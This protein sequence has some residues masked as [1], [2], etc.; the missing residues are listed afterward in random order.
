MGEDV[1]GFIIYR[2]FYMGISLLSSE[3]KGK[4][5]EALFADMGEGE[6]PSLDPVTHAIFNMMLPS[7]HDAQDSFSRRSEASRENGRLGGRPKKEKVNTEV[8]EFTEEKNKPSEKPRNLENLQVFKNLN[9]IDKN[10]IEEINTPH[11]PQASDCELSLFDISSASPAECDSSPIGEKKERINTPPLP[12]TGGKVCADEYELSCGTSANSM[13]TRPCEAS[14][15]ADE[16]KAQSSLQ[17]GGMEPRL[18]CPPNGDVTNTSDTGSRANSMDTRPC[19]AKGRKAKTP[20]MPKGADLPPYTE[21]FERIW[22]KYPRKDA[23]GKAYKAYMELL[24]AGA[25]PETDDLIERITYR[26][27]EPDWEREN[28][29]YV[30]YFSTWLHNRGWEDAGCFSDTTPEQRARN[31]RASAIYAKYN[32]GMWKPGLTVEQVEENCD[33]MYAELEAEGLL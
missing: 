3:Q 24:K 9:R 32:G 22:A 18:C 13:D 30:P 2:K 5:M 21:Q 29:K 17:A 20:R 12:P 7:V 11:T 6:M 4:L 33:R 14:L 16:I 28:G 23:K 27:F 1:K 19:E 26:K 8:S 25:L 10:R 15:A 31:E